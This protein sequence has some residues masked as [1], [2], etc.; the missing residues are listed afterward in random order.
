[1]GQ[2]CIIAT[3]L[4]CIHIGNLLLNG[5]EAADDPY[6]DVVLHIARTVDSILYLN[7]V[8]WHPRL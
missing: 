3:R 4:S 2:V 8:I 1:M 6:S 5:V 7:L